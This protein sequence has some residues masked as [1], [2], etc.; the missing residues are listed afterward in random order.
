MTLKSNLIYKFCFFFLFCAG[1]K[2]FSELDVLMDTTVAMFLMADMF[3]VFL[4]LQIIFICMSWATIW[5]LFNGALL[6]L[7]GDQF[8]IAMAKAVSNRMRILKW[9]KLILTLLCRF[10]EVSL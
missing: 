8:M 10:C 4:K 6:I 2:H 7:I 1:G 3:P 9:A 5:R